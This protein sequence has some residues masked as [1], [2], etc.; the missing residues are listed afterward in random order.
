M[1]DCFQEGS[2][3]IRTAVKGRI[4]VIAT[5][6]RQQG[7]HLCR[8]AALRKQAIESATVFRQRLAALRWDAPLPLLG[9]MTARAFPA[10][11]CSCCWHQ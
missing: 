5:Q 11:A 6:I 2:A 9:D 3:P 1:N 8:A 7:K 4:R 10:K